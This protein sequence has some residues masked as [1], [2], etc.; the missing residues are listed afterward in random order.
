MA[1]SKLRALVPV[2]SGGDRNQR[3]AKDALRLL[4]ESHLYRPD[5]VLWLRDVASGQLRPRSVEY[6][7]VQEQICTAAAEQGEWELL[8]SVSKRIYEKFPSSFRT[9]LMF[10]RRREALSLWPDALKTYMEL[11]ADDPMCRLAYKRQVA[12]LKSQQKVP[13]AIAMLNYYLSHFGTDGEAW[14]ELAVLCLEQTRISHAL[15]AANEL[16]L[17]DP[18]NHA[19]HTLVADIYMTAGDKEEVVLARKHYAASLSARKKKNLRALYGM[20]LAASVLDQNYE[21][22]T[23]EQVHNLKMLNWAK[24]AISGTYLELPNADEYAF[25]PEVLEKGIR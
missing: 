20:W 19:S 15:Y 24:E 6:W 12:V 21:L 13:E 11:V 8:K 14:A 3:G 1:A 16:V 2:T 18:N 9:R 5:L 17:I 4:R 22:S 23:E 7:D 25:V 10:G